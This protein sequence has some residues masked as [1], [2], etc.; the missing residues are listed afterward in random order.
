MSA[1]GFYA[2]DLAWV[3][4][5]AFGTIAE[6]G[7]GRLLAELAERRVLRGLVVELGAGSGIAAARLA[8]TGYDVHGVELSPDMIALARGR[9]P[10][11][12]FVERS[13]WDAKL[14][15]CVAV[16]SF[17]ECLNYVADPT[18]GAAALPGLLQR[19]HEALEPGGILLFDVAGPGREPAGTRR[20]WFEG[21]GWMLCLDAAEDPAGPSLERRITLFRE[22]GGAYR[23]SDEVHRL[24]LY[25]PDG[26][27]GELRAL[28]FEVQTLAGY[29]GAHPFG[30]GHAGFIARKSSR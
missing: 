5:A 16:A 23:R 1:G 6:Q 22:T 8:E 9:A 15:R 21:A 7:A 14:P 11:A 19:V 12:T 4:D 26:V 29:R 2:A 18:A 17:G 20:T 24:W 27:A 30:P 28:R 3:H 13:L 25:E 10:S